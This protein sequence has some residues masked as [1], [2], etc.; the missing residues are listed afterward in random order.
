MF[1]W[2]PWT[3]ST[4]TISQLNIFNFRCT[5]NQ[6]CINMDMNSHC[7]LYGRCVCNVG[8]RFDMTNKEQKCIRYKINEE[9]CD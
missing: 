7:T 8:Y 2:W 5:F 9:D 4:T 1:H 3:P 6:Q